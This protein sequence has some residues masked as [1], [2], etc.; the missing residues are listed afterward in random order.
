MNTVLD[1]VVESQVL[2]SSSNYTPHLRNLCLQ[3]YLFHCKRLVDSGH[4][5]NVLCIQIAQTKKSMRHTEAAL[6]QWVVQEGRGLV[7]VVNKMDLLAGS[8][9]ARLRSLVMKAV[10]EEIQK[11]LPQ[12]QSP[13]FFVPLVFIRIVVAFH[14]Q[15]SRLHLD[16]AN[17]GDLPLYLC[18]RVDLTLGLFQVTGVPIVFVSALEGKGR[19]SVMRHVNESYRLWCV[20]LPTAKLNRW[21]RKVCA[22]YDSSCDSFKCLNYKWKVHF[23]S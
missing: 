21:L 13:W 16:V 10:P 8:E 9:Q 15:E 17:H 7:V 12:V 4:W 19:A 20:R 22:L 5:A 14:L 2:S 18:G 6:A 3:I 23:G 11:L 1:V